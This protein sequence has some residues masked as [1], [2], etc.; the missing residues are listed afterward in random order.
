MNLIYDSKESRP[1]WERYL[2][3]LWLTLVAGAVLAAMLF[4]VS[5]G[6]A[7]N[8]QAGGDQAPGWYTALAS[9]ARWPPLLIILL[10]EAAVVYR[11]APN[12]KPP[13]RFITPGA[14]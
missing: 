12:R 5:V 4:M 3:G 13:W 6:Q 7:V 14:V 10:V 1:C 9:V 2:V 11:V 8:Q